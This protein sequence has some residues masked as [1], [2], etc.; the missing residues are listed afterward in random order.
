MDILLALLPILVISILYNCVRNAMRKHMQYVFMYCPK[1][2]NE[3]IKNG[4]VLEPGRDT[5][6]Y[7]CNRCGVISFWDI[8]HYPVPVIRTCADC[9]H[10]KLNNCGEAVCEENCSSNTQTCFEYRSC[11]AEGEKNG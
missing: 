1:C 7:M 4:V 2:G 9:V 5:V 10:M 8:A 11:K 6:K 3:L